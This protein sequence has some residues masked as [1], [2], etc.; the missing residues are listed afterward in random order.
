MSVI[1]G[2]IVSN[3]MD[4][5]IR[6]VVLTVLNAPFNIPIAC[7]IFINPWIALPTTNKIGPT[8][9]TS[10]ANVTIICLTGPGKLFSQRTN[11]VSPLTIFV[12]TPVVS[13]K[14]YCNPS[15]ALLNC[16]NAPLNV[17]LNVLAISSAVPSLFS[18]DL[19]KSSILSAPVLHKIPIPL[20]LS[21]VNVVI[22]AAVLCASPIPFVALSTSRIMS[23]ILLK[24]PLAS[25]TFTDVF[26]ICIAPFF[27]FWVISLIIAF[28][29]VPPSLPLRPASA[30]LPNIAVV[31]SK[32]IPALCALTAQFLNASP[33]ISVVVFELACA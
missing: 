6:K 1:T 29:A 25:C 21:A 18:S 17:L 9:A 22:S 14:S 8:A 19:V 5:K 15:Q 7:F 20:I 10:R 30:N 24:L 2:T 27:I 4:L 13:P 33:S 31:S 3:R 32:L 12:N 26:P 28:K 23:V 11:T 16:F